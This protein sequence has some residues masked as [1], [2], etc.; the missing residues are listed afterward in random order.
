M[1]TLTPQPTAAQLADKGIARALQNEH[2][3]WRE[4]IMEFA[5]KF[6]SM[7]PYFR[8]EHM[9]YTW[10]ATPNATEPHHPNVWGGI[11]RLM[12]KE[13]LIEFVRYEKTLAYRGKGH[14]SILYKSLVYTGT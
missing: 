7:H 4:D 8:I 9:R 3:K 10:L 13:G 11:G 6:S 12:V 14:L 5:R 2:T 1:N